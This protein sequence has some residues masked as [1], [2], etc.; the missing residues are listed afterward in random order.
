MFSG[1]FTTKTFWVGLATLLGGVSAI[2][3]AGV[4]LDLSSVTAIIDTIQALV[5]TDGWEAVMLGLAIITGRH[6]IS[7][8]GK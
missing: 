7:K 1:L 6:A 3:G 4:A 8:M 5:A 2:V